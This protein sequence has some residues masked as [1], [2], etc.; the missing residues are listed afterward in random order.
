[1]PFTEPKAEAAQAQREDSRYDVDSQC[2]KESAI[3][4]RAIRA[5]GKYRSGYHDIARNH[6]AYLDDRWP[7]S[8]ANGC[9]ASE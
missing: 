3:V 1:M 8:A 2:P 7:L 5:V 4:A 6:D 9:G